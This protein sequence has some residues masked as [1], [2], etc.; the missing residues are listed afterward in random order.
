MKDLI[1][2]IKITVP[3]DGLV[4]KLSLGRPLNIKLGFD[5]TAPDLHL[6]H[7][8]V[9]RKLRQFQDAGHNVI[10]IIG[11]FTARIGDPSGRN[12]TRP[13]LTENKIQENAR[14]Y[15]LQLSKVLD[16]TKLTIRS[17]SEWFHDMDLA[18]V[19]TLLSSV[20]L[21]QMM[22]RNDFGERFREG[23]SIALHELVYPVMQGYDSVMIEADVE[24]GGTDQ[25]FNCMVGKTMQES[26]GRGSQVVVCM[27]LL[28]GT[29]GKEKMSKSKNN[30]IGLTD[31]PVNMFGKIMSVPD[32]VIAEYLEL[33][34]R[35]DNVAKQKILESLRAGVANPME[36]KK[37]VAANVVAVYHDNVSAQI[38]QQNF[39]TKVQKKILTDDDYQDVL[40]E[41]LGIG[42]GVSILD[43]CRALTPEQSR[44]NIRRLAAAGAISI[45]GR[46]IDDLTQPIE[47]IGKPF[48]LKIGKRRFFNVHNR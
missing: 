5:P 36:I 48:R 16:S 39:E 35:F 30:Y 8:V 43:L 18:G 3:K 28:R 34:A 14:T 41:N 10:V 24:I 26:M 22:Q 20:T 44:S 38:A 12:K 25:L 1:D 13:P 31:S 29:D 11:D 4:R 32:D 40:V 45:N 47:A 7:A 17:N 37:M 6:G 23:R 33:A 15:V 19:L 42:E 46:M 2:D 21:A 9:L 27:P